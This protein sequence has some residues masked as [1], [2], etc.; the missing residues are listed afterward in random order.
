VAPVSVS[1]RRPGYLLA[2]TIVLQVVLISAQVTTS[3]GVPLLQSVVFG[4]FAEVQRWSSAAV[5]SVRGVWTGYFDLRDVRAENEAL[6]RELDA[7]QIRL[8]EERAAAKRA[9]Q[10]R[11]LLDLHERAG[12][13]TTAAEV[14][15]AAASPE[16][17]TITIDKARHGGDFARRR[18]RARDSPERSRVEGPIAHRPERRGR[19]LD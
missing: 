2:A 19:G 6:K 16:F 3:T 7:M 11:Q 5:D 13:D 14:I 10:F 17:R 9:D 4:T 15:A 8:Q 12:V 1:L 18:G